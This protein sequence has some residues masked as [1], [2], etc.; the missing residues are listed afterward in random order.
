[1]KQIWAPWRTEYVRMKKPEGCILCKKPKEDNDAPNYILYRGD[2][3]FALMNKYP[4]SPGHLMVAPYRHIANL[5]ELTNEEI[6]EHFEIVS[7]GVKLLRQVFNPDGFN[8]GIN[9]GKVA[10][11]GI[12]GH[13]HSHIVPRWR[14]DTNFMPIMSGTRVISEALAETY[15][16]LKGKF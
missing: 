13:I 1:M 8:I 9:M 12:D 5:E 14:G 3:N 15:K 4:Y 11:A 6:G 7:Q 10:G 16:K 2:K